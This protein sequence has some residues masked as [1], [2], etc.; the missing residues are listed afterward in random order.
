MIPRMPENRA[1]SGVLYKEAWLDIKQINTPD[2]TYDSI[3][4]SCL[5]TYCVELSLKLVNKIINRLW[6]IMYKI[7]PKK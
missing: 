4:R 1:V 5:M 3:M 6:I 7:G 2:R